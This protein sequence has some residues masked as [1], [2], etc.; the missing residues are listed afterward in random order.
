MSNTTF[1]LNIVTYLQHQ[2]LFYRHREMFQF[3]FVCH[4]LHFELPKLG[5]NFNW[6]FY[7]WITYSPFKVPVHLLSIVLF[8][9]GGCFFS[10]CKTCIRVWSVKYRKY[11]FVRKVYAKQ[12]VCI[13]S[14][15]LAFSNLSV[16]ASESFVKT[17]FGSTLHLLYLLPSRGAGSTLCRPE[18]RGQHSAGCRCSS[19]CVRTPT[20]A[21]KQ[22]ATLFFK[23]ATATPSI[24]IPP[25]IF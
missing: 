13:V 10:T 16:F 18:G 5:W 8:V 3:P 6:N 9:F 22:L 2:L 15:F 21:F 19:H 11:V 4:G 7:L 12:N 20:I 24:F 1:V 17:W 25:F 14:F 23:R